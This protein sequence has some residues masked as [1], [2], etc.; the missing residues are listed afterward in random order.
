MI[1]T[2]VTFQTPSMDGA[3]PLASAAIAPVAAQASASAARPAKAP[4]PAS[5]A[6]LQVLIMVFPR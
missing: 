6:G 5:P 4:R 3:F 1:T 2:S